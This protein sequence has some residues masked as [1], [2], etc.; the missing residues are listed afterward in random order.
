MTICEDLH[1][2]KNEESEKWRYQTSCTQIENFNRRHTDKA[3]I[4]SNGRLKAAENYDKMEEEKERTPTVHM[5]QKS[6]ICY[7]TEKCT[8]S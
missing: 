5:N 4:K 3:T 6:F 7:F 8:R 2:V 1:E